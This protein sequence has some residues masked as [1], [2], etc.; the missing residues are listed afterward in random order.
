MKL[1]LTFLVLSLFSLSTF[2]QTETAATTPAPGND[3]ITTAP[4]EAPA[5]EV[6]AKKHHGKKAKKHH[7]KK[8]HKKHKSM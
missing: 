8:K 6:K 1:T 7:A 4:A 5:K 3:Q 2:A